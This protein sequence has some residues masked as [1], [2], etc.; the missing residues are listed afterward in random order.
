MS[1]SQNN[2]QPSSYFD[3][4]ALL[5]MQGPVEAFFRGDTPKEIYKI[6]GQP[7]PASFTDGHKSEVP[8]YLIDV[9][10][11]SEYMQQ[12]KFPKSC[13]EKTLEVMK[14][15]A[16]CVRLSAL[17]NDFYAYN[18]RIA[19]LAG[20]M[21]G[22]EIAQTLLASFRK[23]FPKM[24]NLALHM[25]EKSA[26]TAKLDRFEERLVRIGAAQSNAFREWRYGAEKENRRGKKRKFNTFHGC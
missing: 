12:W 2:I 26:E 9:L 5:A 20:G 10:R 1:L 19:E 14:A 24:Q 21:A 8:A 15:D 6:L 4:D 18:A 3:A 11:R 23:R 17:N 7:V 16:S 13:Q 25:G 22:A